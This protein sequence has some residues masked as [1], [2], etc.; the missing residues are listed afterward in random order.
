MQENPLF[1]ADLVFMPYKRQGLKGAVKNEQ[2]TVAFAKLREP[3][4]EESLGEGM[5]ESLFEAIRDNILQQQL[6]E[7]TKVRLTITSKEYA[8][9]TVQSGPYTNTKY[10]IPVSEFVK[11]GEFVHTMFESLARKMNSVQNMNPTIGFKATLTFITYP[12]KRGKGPA[13]KSPGRLP[14]DLLHRNKDYMVQ[15]DNGDELC[16]TRAI[17]T[18][19]GYVDGDPNKQYRNLRERLAKQPYREAG[20]PEGPCVYA[21]LEKFQAYLGRQKDKLIVVH[22]ISCAIIFNG[23]VDEYEKFI[24]LVKHGAHYNGLRSMIAF[25]NRSYVTFNG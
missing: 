20:V 14:F 15:I 21:E 22:Y 5:S 8:N 10:R 24:Y 4:K 2:F 7:R 9:S 19:K 17:V 16:C 12:E 23:K 1:R 6:D 18:M 25:L 3:S 11:R 13:S